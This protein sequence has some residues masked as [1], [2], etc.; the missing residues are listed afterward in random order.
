M[1]YLVGILVVIFLAILGIV[2]LVGGGGNNDSASKPAKL[3]KTAD[4]ENSDGASISWTHQGQLVGDDKYRSIRVTVTRST[5]KIEILSGYQDR[6]ERTNEYPNTAAAFSTF[7]RALDNQGFGK[8]RTVKQPDDRGICPLGNRFIY[9]LT[10]NSQE[11]MRTWSDTCLTANGPFG[12]GTNAVATIQQLFRAQIP[13]YY[14]YTANVQ[15]S[16]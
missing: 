6:V 12:G 8:E 10:D 9:R 3:S 4:Y 7:T 2:L 13:D 1:R 5:R 14:N 16:Y 11:I 15:L